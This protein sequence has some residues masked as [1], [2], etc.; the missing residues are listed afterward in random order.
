MAWTDAPTVDAALLE[1]M[2]DSA[3]L[4]NAVAFAYVRVFYRIHRHGPVPFDYDLL[5]S[6]A[7]VGREHFAT[8][9]FPQIEHLF[10][11]E[12]GL[13]NLP[14]TE[15]EVPNQAEGYQRRAARSEAGRIAANARWTAKKSAL[16][17]YANDANRMPDAYAEDANSMRSAYESHAISMPATE[18]PHA[19]LH[20]AA[21]TPHG[22][23]A[24]A[25]A[26]VD[27]D[28][29]PLESE[30]V[31]ERKFVFVERGGTGGS[32]NST[33]SDA[34]MHAEPMRLDAEVHAE[35]MRSVT[36][37]AHPAAASISPHWQPSSRVRR[38]IARLGLNLE[39]VVREFRHQ[40]LGAGTMSSDFN[41]EFLGW[42]RR[43]VEK[44]LA[45]TG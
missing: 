26:R 16:A 36:P 29:S 37:Q 11:V 6:I 7:Q 38:E 2:A 28:C 35:P 43:A 13:L 31:K 23:L 34:E 12:G 18:N 27:S 5:A 20:A 39:A 15:A 8:R 45:A 24:R 4:T 32:T 19:N 25:G 42:A 30:K 44:S 33:S 22:V 40:H 14:T 21:S 3:G 10:R 17:P 1:L 41:G 9:V